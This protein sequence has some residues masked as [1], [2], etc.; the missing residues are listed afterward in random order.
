M[1]RLWRGSR[2]PAGVTGR[3]V[4][5]SGCRSRIGH[6]MTPRHL[7]LF[8]W[9]GPC[10]SR[11]LLFNTVSHFPS[12]SFPNYQFHHLTSITRHS[13]MPPSFDIDG[14]PRSAQTNPRPRHRQKLHLKINFF[15]TC[16]FSSNLF[17][18]LQPCQH[19]PLRMVIIA[20]PI[21]SMCLRRLRS[22]IL[23]SCALSWMKVHSA[24]LTLLLDYILSFI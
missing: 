3:G 2:D 4:P 15:A 7:L 14:H 22:L 17:T 21:L 6:F 16:S 12:L 5:G 23:T 10:Q 19:F 1:T 24:A 18:T 11:S 8:V 9:P 13:L 20:P